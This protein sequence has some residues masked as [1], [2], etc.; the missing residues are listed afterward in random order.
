MHSHVL[1]FF[2]FRVWAFGLFHETYFDYDVFHVNLQ[3]DAGNTEW[4]RRFPPPP[5]IESG[6]FHQDGAFIQC[7]QGNIN[8]FIELQW[9]DFN[10]KIPI[11][12]YNVAQHEFSM[13]LL[14][15]VVSDFFLNY[16][17]PY[18]FF[19]IAK[20]LYYHQFFIVP[21]FFSLYANYM[22]SPLIC[23]LKGLV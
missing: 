21:Y 8:Q 3:P 14:C 16:L 12:S 11:F 4:K 17:F 9:A 18:F 6:P 7:F 15:W 2:S 19:S 23:Q 13:Q 1:L 10:Y 22:Q 5:R 20:M